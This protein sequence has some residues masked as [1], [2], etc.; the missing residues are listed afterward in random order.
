M[1]FTLLSAW[2]LLYRTF[3]SAMQNGFLE[4]WFFVAILLIGVL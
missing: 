3:M 2:G 4:L 1:V